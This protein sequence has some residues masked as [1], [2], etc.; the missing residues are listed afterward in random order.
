MIDLLLL[1]V[2]FLFIFMFSA[3]LIVNLAIVIGAYFFLRIYK[4]GKSS[5]WT[6]SVMSF[7]AK[8]RTYPLR[9]ET[10]TEIFE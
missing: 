5:H 3:N 6:S 4:K 1:L 8:P 9:R 7:L 2:I 10:E